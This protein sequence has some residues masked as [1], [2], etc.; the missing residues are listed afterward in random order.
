MIDTLLQ[1]DYKN[2]TQ[3]I[4]KSER[5]SSNERVYVFLIYYFLKLI[6]TEFAWPSL[7]AASEKPLI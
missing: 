5:K 6:G 7:V 2:D 1:T 3:L 4:T